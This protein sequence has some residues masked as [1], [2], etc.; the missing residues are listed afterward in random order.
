M[1]AEARQSELLHRAAASFSIAANRVFPTTRVL[2]AGDDGFVE[3]AGPATV[4]VVGFGTSTWSKDKSRFETL[5]AVDV[6]GGEIESPNTWV[7]GPS[8]T[9][10]GEELPGDLAPA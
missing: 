2:V 3:V 7:R 6:L 5:F 10:S 1:R 4:K 8:F 9:A